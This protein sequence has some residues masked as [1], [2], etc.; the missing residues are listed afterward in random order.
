MSTNA[1]PPQGAPRRDPDRRQLQVLPASDD[2]RAR[3]AGATLVPL[4]HGTIA[5]VS[6]IESWLDTD[7]LIACRTPT[8]GRAEL[9]A[10]TT[11]PNVQEM[12]PDRFFASLYSDFGLHPINVPPPYVARFT[13]PLVPTAGEHRELRLQ[14]SDSFHDTEMPACSW[15]ITRVEGVEVDRPLPARQVRLHSKTGA[16]GALVMEKPF[17]TDLCRGNGD[18]DRGYPPCVLESSGDPPSG[19]PERSPAR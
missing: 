2:A 5:A 7:R 10:G 11:E 15:H 9:C 12:A 16:P 18:M 19:A 4:S 8:D 17:G 6:S 3:L 13:I 14:P 1:A